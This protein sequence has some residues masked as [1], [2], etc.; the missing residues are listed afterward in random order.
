M[1]DFK[2]ENAPHSNC[3]TLHSGAYSSPG[4]DPYLDL[5]GLLLRRM[6]GKAVEGDR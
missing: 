3:P 2:V 6:G 4:S 5:M 1:S